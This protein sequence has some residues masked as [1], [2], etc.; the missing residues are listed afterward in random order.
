MGFWPWDKR[1]ADLCWSSI[2]FKL[3]DLLRADVALSQKIGG[4]ESIL[5]RSLAF[6]SPKFFI[7]FPIP[8]AIIFQSPELAGL[9]GLWKPVRGLGAWSSVAAQFKFMGEMGEMGEMDGRLGYIMLHPFYLHNVNIYIHNYI[10]IYFT[11]LY[12]IYVIYLSLSIYICDMPGD[13]GSQKAHWPSL[14]VSQWHCWKF[15]SNWGQTRLTLAQML[16]RLDELLIFTYIIQKD[17]K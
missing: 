10:Y 2:R 3:S 13:K 9:G 8:G 4:I 16:M 6:F 5:F 11:Y 12:I 14:H 7:I 1:L 15:C 17:R